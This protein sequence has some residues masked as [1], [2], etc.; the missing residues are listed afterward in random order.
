MPFDTSISVPKTRTDKM[1][2][3][4]YHCPVCAL[5]ENPHNIANIF[6]GHAATL[7]ASAFTRFVFP[8]ISVAED[9]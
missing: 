1:W 4:H 8:E 7:K 5:R 2:G 9:V 3:K 6:K